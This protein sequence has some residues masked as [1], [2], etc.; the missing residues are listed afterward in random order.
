MDSTTWRELWTLLPGWRHI[1]VDLPG[2]G[3]SAP[4]APGWTLPEMAAQL[5]SVARATGAERMVALSMGSV[6]ALQLAIDEPATVRRLV[7]GAPTISGRPAERGTDD[8]YRQLAFIRRMGPA[9][10]LDDVPGH[11]ADVWMRSPPDIFKGTLKH[12]ALRAALRGVILRHRWD[13]L[14]N[15]ALR[16]LTAHHQTA[17]DLGRVTAAT[18]VVHGDEDMPTF[19]DNA[20]ILGAA[21][22]DCRLVNLPGAGHLCL[23]ERP[24]EAA[25][26][27]DHHLR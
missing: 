7:V 22:P 26:V 2:H 4:L 16:A 6:L 15:G 13:E 5:G 25:A 1:G 14:T 24:D 20:R 8:R 9:A 27:I 23:L 10:G 3:G 18:L 12:P 21:V 11:L 19:L 17:D